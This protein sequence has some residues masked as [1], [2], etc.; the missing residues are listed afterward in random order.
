VSASAARC[1]RA[2]H[3]HTTRPARRRTARAR[4]ARTR[5][6]GARNASMGS[7]SAHNAK[8]HST[9]TKHGPAHPRGVDDVDERRPHDLDERCTSAPHARTA[10][11]RTAWARAAGMGSSMHMSTTNCTSTPCTQYGHADVRSAG[12]QSSGPHCAHSAGTHG[13]RRGRMHAHG[14]CL[15]CRVPSVCTSEGRGNAAAHWRATG[16]KGE[17]EMNRSVVALACR[18]RSSAPWS[19]GGPV[20]RGDAETRRACVRMSLWCW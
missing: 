19:R 14:A 10:R 9:S 6:A 11:A 4:T 12:T 7:A 3:K 15:P 13:V 16:M 2:L 20:E 18:W 8:M 5:T 17:S 1:S